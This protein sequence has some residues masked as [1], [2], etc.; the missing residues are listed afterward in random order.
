LARARGVPPAHA[1]G[2]RRSRAARAFVRGQPRGRVSLARVR[3]LA[4]DPAVARPGRDWRVSLPR[5]SPDDLR[6]E[7]ERTRAT[8]RRRYGPAARALFLVMDTIYGRPR[9]LSKFKV[10][11]VVARVP[12]QAWENVA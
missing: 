8:P 3:G 6:N 9:S 5:F 12:Y 2:H 1:R 7:A 11:E 4:P 10:L